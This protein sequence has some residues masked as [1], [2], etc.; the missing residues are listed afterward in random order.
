[1][2]PDA[3]M[4]VG[5]DLT[6]STDPQ[7]TRYKDKMEEGMVSASLPLFTYTTGSK[8]IDGITSATSKYFAKKGLVYTYREGKRF[9]TSH[10][11]MK[12]WIDAI[13]HGTETSCNIE[14]GF[15]EAITCHMATES[16]LHKKVVEWDSVNRK[17]I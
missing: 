1:M 15:E 10:L 6:V 13:R 12:E 2:V 16:Y 5:R 3:H 8:E 9:N 4:E 11:H 14:R 7:S 17:F